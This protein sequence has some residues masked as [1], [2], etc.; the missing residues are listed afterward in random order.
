[1]THSKSLL[2]K[3]LLDVKDLSV[4][5]GS[6]RAVQD[7]SYQLKAGEIAALVGESGSGKTVSALALI[8]LLPPKTEVTGEAKF[9]GHSLLNQPETLMRDLR[10]NKISMIFQEPLSALNPLHR[11]E[12]Q[13][14]E[15]LEIHK[16]MTP[17]QADARIHELLELVGLPVEPRILRAFPHELSGGQRQRVM[18]AMALANEPDILIADEPT[19]ALDVTTETQILDLLKDLQKKLSQKEKGP[20]KGMAML[21]ITHDLGVVQKMAETVHV[22]KGGKLVESGATE[23]I[24]KNPQDAYTKMLLASS[25]RGTPPPIPKEAKTVI[26][27]KNLKVWFPIK[28][29]VLRRTTGYV[30]AVDG[31][32]LTLKAGQ[33]VG[34]VGESGSGK[35]TLVNGLLRLTSSDGKINFDGTR[36]DTLASKDLRRHRRHMQIVFQDPFGAL[37]PRLSV[38]DIIGEGLDIHEPHLPRQERQQRITQALKQVNLTPDMVK[39]YPHEFSGGQRQRI[40]IARALVL[41]PKLLVLD[42]PTS[43]LDLSVQAQIIDLLRDL[44]AQH[45]LAYLFISHDLKVVKAMAHDILVLKDGQVVESGPA[46]QI[47]HHPTQAYTQSLIQA[48]K[49]MDL[50]MDA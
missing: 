43:A 39:R 29:G 1:M 17:G 3:A 16:K 40:A 37:S 30:K 49:E 44:Q 4:S 26:E 9:D 25:P 2:P 14:G 20:Q 41:R 10:G 6:V 35:T 48:A 38:G 18:I 7:V 15:V 32:D 13:I 36:L 28:A 50:G 31:I 11:V 27:T 22:M 42:E 8:G 34:I 46:K 47:F 23:Q 5:F 33:T 24:F 21:L 19:T 12:K 45:Q